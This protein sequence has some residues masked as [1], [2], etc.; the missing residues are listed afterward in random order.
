MGSLNIPIQSDGSACPFRQMHIPTRVGLSLTLTNMTK[1]FVRDISNATFNNPA[2]LWF[3]Y[4][5]LD[6]MGNGY[7]AQYVLTVGIT[8]TIASIKSDLIS[9]IIS[10][11]S[12]NGYT[13]AA[14]DFVWLAP[15][16]SALPSGAIADAPAD[17]VTNYNVVTTLLGSL[18]GAVNAANTKQNDIAT[19]LNALLLACRAEGIITP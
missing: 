16:G 3:E 1:V 17:A 9:A 8:S 10:A 14:G 4:F 18:T 19:K 5:V 7:D 2:R 13:V 15:N 6:D 12:L 11:A